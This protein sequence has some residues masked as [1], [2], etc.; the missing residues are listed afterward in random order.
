MYFNSKDSVDLRLCR[1]C[2]DTIHFERVLESFENCPK[3][4]LWVK[5][6]KARLD[7]Y[8]LE[9]S[10]NTMQE[11]SREL[12]DAVEGND[13]YDAISKDVE[14]CM[15][16]LFSRVLPEDD[17]EDT[18]PDAPPTPT[19]SDVEY[20]TESDPIDPINSSFTV[21]TA[22]HTNDE[23][24]KSPN[25]EPLP[26]ATYSLPVKVMKLFDQ[27]VGSVLPLG[28]RLAS[29]RVTNNGE[30]RE[31]YPT[32]TV[33]LNGNLTT[34]QKEYVRK[35]VPHAFDPNNYTSAAP[36]ATEPKPQATSKESANILPTPPPSPSPQDAIDQAVMSTPLHGFNE[37]PEAEDETAESPTLKGSDEES[38]D[39]VSSEEDAS[40]ITR[41][42]KKGT[43]S[44]RPTPK[45]E[46]T[47]RSKK[48][49]SKSESEEST[50]NGGGSES[51]DS[52]SG[53]DI[54]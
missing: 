26:I 20:I 49:N 14:N 8:A 46:M 4:M 18:C 40:V 37:L 54:I 28:S 44:L 2:R 30:I 45:L 23:F 41:D 39:L 19:S 21:T 7:T 27:P 6:N 5:E 51:D 33:N 15:A 42:K 50:E 12:R 34:L 36:Q 24:L 48:N 11:Y 22:H 17:P 52:G 25:S 35:F 32:I 47:L 10:N 31:T 53:S 43:R 1:P 16:F 13:M 9:K 38:A 29:F 3:C